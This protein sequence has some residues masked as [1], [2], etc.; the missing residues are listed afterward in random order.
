MYILSAAYVMIHMVR[1]FIPLLLYIYI[2]IYIYCN[3]LKGGMGNALI[4][5]GSQVSLVA[6]TSLSRGLRIKK[7]VVQIYGITGNTMDIKGQID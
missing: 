7:Q 2:Y 5:T 3:K 6:E 1:N 4:D